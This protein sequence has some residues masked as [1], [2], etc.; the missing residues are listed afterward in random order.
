MSKLP[1]IDEQLLHWIWKQQQFDFFN[2]NTTNGAPVQILS[3]GRLNASDGPDFKQAEVVIADLK[4]Y[5]DIEIHWKVGDWKAH[6]HHTD[7][8]FNN[9]ILHV[10]F[11]NTTQQA[12]RKDG[13]TIPTLVLADKLPKPLHQFLD[14]YL[15]KPHLPCSGKLSFISEEAFKT[16]LK[17]AHKEYFEQKVDYLLDFYDPSLPPSQAWIKM[18]GIALCDGLG[19]AHNRQPMQHLAKALINLLH[20]IRSPE[21][22]CEK[23]LEYSGIRTENAQ[24]KNN[25]WNHKGCRPGNHPEARIQQAAYI[26]WHIHQIPFEQWVQHPPQK[27]WQDLLNNI[28]TTPSLGKERASI[29]FGTVFLPAIYLLG[30]LLHSGKLKTKSWQLWH[31]HKAKIP[32]SLLKKFKNADIPSEIYQQKLGS[33]YQLREYCRPRNCQNCKVFKNA[34]SS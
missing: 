13:S 21:G 27:L 28:K 4:W 6:G 14:Q 33:I 1:A 22:L 18:L 16:Q 8:N 24:R 12:Y 15:Q 25:N 11:E 9:V 23:A 34:I 17:K 10:V 19:I 2:L 20:T 30:D 31:K 32:K 26:L 7:P 3:P 29:L 5:G